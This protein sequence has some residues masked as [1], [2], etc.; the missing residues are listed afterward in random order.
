M[1]STDAVTTTVLGLL[2]ACEWY[3]EADGESEPCARRSRFT[4]ERSDHDPSYRPASDRAATEACEAHLADTV[5]AL[6]DGDDT[7]HAVVA[8]RWD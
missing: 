8:P 4:V 7:I 1:N 2:R 6:M 3:V 5:M